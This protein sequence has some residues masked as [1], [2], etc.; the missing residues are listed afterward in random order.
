MTQF[1]AKLN[2]HSKN[3]M[4]EFSIIRSDSYPGNLP[5]RVKS[6]SRVS[7]DDV[8]K[9][10][11]FKNDYVSY[12]IPS[13]TLM[14]WCF[15]VVK[16]FKTWILKPKNEIERKL[17]E[18]RFDYIKLVSCC[19][20]IVC[21][22][23]KFDYRIFEYDRFWSVKITRKLVFRLRTP[24][25]YCYREK[26]QSEAKRSFEQIHHFFWNHNNFK[27]AENIV[28]KGNSIMLK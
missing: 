20:I 19:N 3:C 5:E 8:S 21:I 10:L 12:H 2:R 23:S 16:H 11:S 28:S 25:F 6:Y 27:F 9:G 4:D 18:H 17:S 13:K 26:K 24:I 1:W 14:K 22:S 15:V 7:K